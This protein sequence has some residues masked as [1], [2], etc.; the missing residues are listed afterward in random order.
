MG[1]AGKVPPRRARAAA[2]SLIP[3]TTG[4][5]AAVGLVLPELKGKLDGMAIRVPTPNVSLVDLIV[6]V[7]RD[8]TEEEV[9]RVLREAAE[10][11]LKRIL[12]Y[13]EE[14]LVS[15]DFN[16]DTHSAIVDASLT[17]VID[18]RLVKV[19]AWYDNETGYSSRLIDLAKY[20]A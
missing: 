10:G 19:M 5:A 2:L 9:N 16:G 3:T 7:E 17:K 4:A 20:I 12:R 1:S 8:T 15:C 6:E 18:K 11:E 14:E 13:E